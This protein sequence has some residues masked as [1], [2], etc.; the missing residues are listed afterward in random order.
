MASVGIAG[1]SKSTLGR[2]P[3]AAGQD[4]CRKL[5]Q[6]LSSGCAKRH[7]AHSALAPFGIRGMSVRKFANIKGICTKPCAA[8]SA[9]SS[10]AR[11]SNVSQRNEWFS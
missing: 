7:L 11:C 8:S 9:R 10:H 5:W 2:I 4:F 3:V 6:P 1:Y